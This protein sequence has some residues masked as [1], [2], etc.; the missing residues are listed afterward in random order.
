MTK[1][2][3][4]I[5]ILI[6][7]LIYII[8][9]NN[10]IMYNKKNFKIIN[11]ENVKI[12]NFNKYLFIN[13]NNFNPSIIFECNGVYT[14][15]ID[16]ISTDCNII[17]S[18]RASNTE[19]DLF[20]KIYIKNKNKI[21][22][23]KDDD[24][25]NI[26]LDESNDLYSGYDKVGYEDS[27]FCIIKNNLF[28]LY[29]IFS[30]FNKEV[31]QALSDYNNFNNQIYFTGFKINK[32][33]KNWMLFENN[34]QLYLIYNLLPQLTIYSVDTNYH[35]SLVKDKY[36]NTPNIRGGT[37]PILIDDYFYFFGHFQKEQ[38]KIYFM[39]ITIMN[40]NNF[41]IIGY[42]NNLLD[43]IITTNIIFCRGALYI[44]SL[45]KFIVSVGINDIESKIII[46]DKKYIDNKIIKI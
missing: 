3:I 34:N 7:T 44:K 43:N 11:Y 35:C 9:Y 39:T 31:K 12:I 2:N 13:N 18:Y 10:N 26:I 38:N 5:L 6:L 29:S 33:E 45:Q 42:N 28:L 36:Y 41:E 14:N 15:I 27:R 8:Y 22:Y 19:F 21:T 37:T 40:K 23:S 20:S 17:M 30:S 16:N 1:L 46:I 4:I 24:T 25:I 32:F